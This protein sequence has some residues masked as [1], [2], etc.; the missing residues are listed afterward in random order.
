M[1]QK[2]IKYDPQ[3][4]AILKV[5]KENNITVEKLVRKSCHKIVTEEQNADKMGI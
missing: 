5:M 1:Q 2:A 4:I 3:M